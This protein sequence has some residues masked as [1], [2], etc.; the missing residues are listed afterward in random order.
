MSLLQKRARVLV[1]SPDMN[2]RSLLLEGIFK[3]LDTDTE[4]MCKERLEFGEDFLLSG[5]EKR[6]HCG[7]HSWIFS[8]YLDGSEVIVKCYKETRDELLNKRLGSHLSYC[9]YECKCLNELRHPNI[10]QLIDFDRRVKCVLLEPISNGN[11]L[12]VLRKRRSDPFAPTLTQLLQIAVNITDALKY[13]EGKGM[14]HLAVQAGNVLLHESYIGKLTGFQF[15]RTWKQIQ[16]SGV[17]KAVE[18]RHFKWMDPQALRF[19]SLHRKTVSWSFGVFLYELLT[20]GC[21]PYNNHKSCPEH[22]DFI[23]KP[24]TSLEAR[25]F[26]SV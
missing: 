8:G 15:C 4:E 3:E 7:N 10:I 9:E 17:K 25:I 24:F 20:S 19:E 26:V 23:R 13:L 6:L 22:G 2:T 21:V 18:K 14:V 16:E 1:F 5:I 12:N 11:L